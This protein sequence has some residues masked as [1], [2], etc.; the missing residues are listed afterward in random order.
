METTKKFSLST[1]LFMIK[2]IFRASPIFFPL[3][4]ITSILATLIGPLSLFIVKDAVNEMVE[5]IDGRSTF[6]S[7]MFF[8]LL[9]LLINLV[10][11]PILNY[12][13]TINYNL[14]Y[15]QAD[16]YFRVIALYKLSNLP[17]ES[18]YDHEIHNKFEYTYKYLYMFQQL[19]S[20]VMDVVIGFAFSNLMYIGVIFSFHVLIG[21]YCTILFIVH[22]GFSI[23]FGKMRARADKRQTEATRL[24]NY[25]ARLMTEKENIK[26][27]KVN[28]LRDYLYQKYKA[29]YIQI[30]M[31]IYHIS[32]KEFYV[33]NG[34]N[35]ISFF[36][37]TILTIL[38]L[39]LAFQGNIDL[40]Q[41]SLLEAAGAS[42]IGFSS[43]FQRPARMIMEAVNHA[44]T[45]IEVLYP[46]SKEDRKK[47]KEKE[48]S[49][50]ELKLGGFQEINLENISYKYPSREEVALE[51][52]NFKIRK[53][54]IVSILGYNGSGKTTLSK[55]ISGVLQPTSGTVYY[56]GTP[57]QEIPMEEYYKYFGIAFQDYAKYSLSLRDNIGFG[58]IE[59]L[60]HEEKIK[61]AITKTHLNNIITRLEHGVDTSL[62]K[63]YDKTGQDLSGGQWQR[64]ILARAYMKDP[65]VLIL[66]EPTAS[67]DPFEEERMLEEFRTTIAG[68]TAILI[69]HRISFA[70]LAD[71]IVM[72]EHGKI[73]EEG[74]HEAL[75]AHRGL[76]YRLFT[77]QQ[78]LYQEGVKS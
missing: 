59:E 60:H 66:D 49:P 58:Q 16:R 15:K 78:E 26:E 34:I 3:F 13:K 40:G 64:V 74:T 61:Q 37:I 22:L 71:K 75:L 4:L 20:H 30:K 23:W 12:I 38:L 9:Y 18:M 52:I 72:M 50:F 19:P 11:R 24:Q 35:L 62:G 5:M 41:L 76:Y 47:M 33:N 73:V 14:Y 51:N 45:M 67:I 25:Y 42:L 68:K 17:Q 28:Q 63:Q 27:I 55:M 43:Q 7:V 1:F 65:E 77:A 31:T 56:N 36:S 48:Y 8:V 53:H 39:F 6:Q 46:L 54:E 70:R 21:I 2:S 57:L 69:S 44:P 29:L 32:K 10:L